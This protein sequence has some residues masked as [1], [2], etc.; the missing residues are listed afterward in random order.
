ML[1]LVKKNKDKETAH[2]AKI[3]AKVVIIAI[4]P[5]WNK[6]KVFGG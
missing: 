1:G 2:K 3:A 6:S 5:V 4:P